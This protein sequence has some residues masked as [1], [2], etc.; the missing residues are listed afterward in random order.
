MKDYAIN[1]LKERVLDNNSRSIFI[2][3]HPKKSLSKIDLLSLSD[4]K[5]EISPS[6]II[7]AL[8]FTWHHMPKLNA[9]RFPVAWSTPVDTLL[10][11]SDVLPQSLAKPQDANV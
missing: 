7:F 5:S 1:L 8:P 4:L 6:K 9:K 2:N 3:A 10:Q 11:T